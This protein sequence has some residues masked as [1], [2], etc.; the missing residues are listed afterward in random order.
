MKF[1]HLV[2]INDLLSPT[3]PPLTRNQVWQGLVYRAESPKEFVEHIDEA[4]ILHRHEQGIHRRVIMG[5]LEV[6]DHIY[7]EYESAVHYD[8]QP[9]DLHLGGKL[10]MKIE[11][12]QEM[13]LFVRFI[14]ETPHPEDADPE[15]DKYLSYLKS[16]WQEADIDTIRLIKQLAQE[17]RLG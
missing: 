8:T 7:Y 5:K 2:Q 9:S 15:L 13:A 3:A 11:E 14:Y 1:E 10:W 4:Y 17:G 12:P 6:I 16:A